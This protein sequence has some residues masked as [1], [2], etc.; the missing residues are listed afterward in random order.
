M[1]ATI[2]V[3]TITACIV[4][5]KKKVCKYLA[6]IVLI[7][8]GLTG[9]GLSYVPMQAAVLC[10][11]LCAFMLFQQSNVLWRKMVYAIL[12]G[13][14]LGLA[15][16]IIIPAALVLLVC[17]AVLIILLH[18]KDKGKAFYYLCA[19]IVGVCISVLYIHFVVCP[20][21]D[22]MDAMFFTAG[23]IGKSGYGYDISSFLMQYMLF[24]PLKPLN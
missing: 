12:C 18:W 13:S 24:F 2:A 21:S 6:V 1:W 20:L 15:L 23:Y 8:M 4:Y 11:A 19:G 9:G 17:I 22:I 14:C 16:F 5:D 7:F 10:W 3:S